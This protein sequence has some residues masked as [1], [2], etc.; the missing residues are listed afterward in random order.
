M[1]DHTY[2]EATNSDDEQNGQYVDKG[3]TCTMVGFLASS[4]SANYWQHETNLRKPNIA[5]VPEEY[6]LDLMVASSEEETAKVQGRTISS[7]YDDPDLFTD[8]DIWH[9][10]FVLREI[11]SRPNWAPG[12]KEQR[13]EHV[14]TSTETPTTAD[15]GDQHTIIVPDLTVV[16]HNY[17]LVLDQLQTKIDTTPFEAP[18]REMLISQAERIYRRIQELGIDIDRLQQRFLEHGNPPS[19]ATNYRKV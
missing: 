17:M 12:E 13:E 2:P 14:V 15:M 9:Q 19:A 11:L 5:Y 16:R 1:E 10:E 7:F 4:V 18:E 6:P 3:K 8:A